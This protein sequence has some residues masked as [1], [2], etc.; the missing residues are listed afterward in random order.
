LTENQ[1]VPSSNLGLGTIRFPQA[2]WV[3]RWHIRW[4]TDGAT[5]TRP[6]AALRLY[7]AAPALSS[8]VEKVS[9]EGVASLGRAFRLA[10]LYGG[11][12]KPE[13]TLAELLEGIPD[14]EL[15][16]TALALLAIVDVGLEYD[17]HP[18]LRLTRRERRA[19]E[20][21]WKRRGKARMN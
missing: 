5:C 13:K 10:G 18:P 19:A 1:G 8:S 3:R 9:G 6:V 17:L 20:R 15:R 11:E 12:D 7:R 4:K 14:P 16:T 21:A 2:L